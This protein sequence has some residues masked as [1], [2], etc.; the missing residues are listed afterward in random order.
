[1]RTNRRAQAA[2]N[3]IKHDGK[4]D[5]TLTSETC[6]ADPKFEQEETYI[7]ASIKRGWPINAQDNIQLDQPFYNSW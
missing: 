7:Q 1:M 5:P 6:T 3:L 4:M 2:T